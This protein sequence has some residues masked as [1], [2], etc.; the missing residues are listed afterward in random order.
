MSQRTILLVDD[1]PE[2]LAVNRETLEGCGYRVATVGNGSDALDFLSSTPVDLV[3]TDLRMPKLGGRELLE[4]MRNRNIK[5]EV[6][7]LTGYGTVESAVECIQLGAADYL[8]KPFDIRQ[9]VTK[10][11]K[12]LEERSLR[13]KT[14]GQRGGESELDR[15]L[16]L[17]AAL[18]SQRD[19]K[20]LV[21]EFLVQMRETFR[22]DA[23]AL[24]LREDF[25]PGLGKCVAWGPMLRSN[26]RARKW[27]EAVSKRLM[28]SGSP[29]LFDS[30]AVNNGTG[31]STVSAMVCPVMDGT[32]ALGAAVIIRDLKRG[33]YALPSLQMLTVFASQAASAMEN[34]SAKCRLSDMNL[35]IIT[36][37][38]CSVEAKDIYTK[39]HSERVG[40]FAAQLGREIGLPDRE[41]Q[42][43]SFAGILHDVGK[44]GVPD[45]ILNKPGP[46]SED[47][48]KIMHQHPVMGRDIL[49]NIHTLKDLLPIVYHHHERIDGAGY[50]DGLSGDSIPFLARIVSV[51]DGY[52]AMTTDRAYQ[53]RRSPDE[54][55][56]ILLDGA[57]KQ[58]DEHLVRAW[59]QLMERDKMTC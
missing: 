22:P 33:V 31:T 3:I 8:L 5:S 23:M 20:A 4:E 21:K 24:F 26:S 49:S 12:I 55:Q 53:Q 6:M 48:L 50:P 46:L 59:C 7:F 27:F 51:A 32:G 44:I 30:L 39:G 10:V 28:E 57:G 16:D 40:A 34:L 29:K 38:V 11:E 15:L 19:L 56:S 43:L 2:L 45:N 47:E 17:G 37:H 36:S 1:E 14:Q 13:R 35:E 52:E 9:F 58:W 42:C 54:A 18:R 41:V 25:E